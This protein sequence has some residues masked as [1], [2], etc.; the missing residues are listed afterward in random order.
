[1]RVK[2]V[3]LIILLL[4]T[5]SLV[6]GCLVAAVGL[7]AASTI[8]YVRGDLEAV[9]SERL[10]VLYEATL[11]AM[12]KLDLSVTAKSKDALS[13]MIIARDAQDKKTTIKLKA[14]TDETAKLSIR[15]GVFGSEAKSRL[16]YREIQE[17]L[18]R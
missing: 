9:E 14:V 15:V 11:R 18:P 3:S 7:G 4:G 8:A 5:A 16:I 1:M 2:Q 6:Q 17:N 10:D 12:E 13:A